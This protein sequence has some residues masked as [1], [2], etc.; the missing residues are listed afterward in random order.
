M[1]LLPAIA[2]G[3]FVKSKPDDYACI[4]LAHPAMKANREISASS[5]VF[6]QHAQKVLSGL[7]IIAVAGEFI[8]VEFGA[9]VCFQSRA[10]NVIIGTFASSVNGSC[11]H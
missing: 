7:T 5:W 2:I 3:S 11:E 4:M 9:I 8:H 1:L 6:A 10:N